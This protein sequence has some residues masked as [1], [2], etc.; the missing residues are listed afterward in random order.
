MW[1]SRHQPWTQTTHNPRPPRMGGAR[2]HHPEI[3][4]QTEMPEAKCTLP[5]GFSPS[6]SWSSLHL[7]GRRPQLNGQ[8][9]RKCAHPH[10][11]TRKRAFMSIS[12]ALSCGGQR[13]C[14][15]FYKRD[16][17]MPVGFE[18]IGPTPLH[19]P[20]WAYPGHRPHPRPT[21]RPGRSAS[22]SSASGAPE[23]KR[24]CR[25]PCRR[26]SPPCGAAAPRARR[27][28]KPGNY[29]RP[30]GASMERW[31]GGAR[32]ERASVDAERRGGTMAREVAAAT[33]S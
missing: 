27:S 13:P 33:R 20:L 19:R 30:G 1:H 6:S 32:R 29:P 23:T 17:D 14:L 22:A 5:S 18:H 8:P 26:P 24:T 12:L 4:L 16:D 10:K 9:R 7:R 3:P 11:A 31:D 15:A 28:R 2:S 25:A 21:P